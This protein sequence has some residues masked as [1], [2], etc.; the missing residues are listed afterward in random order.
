M[1]IDITKCEIRTPKDPL[2]LRHLYEM[3]AEVFPVERKLFQDI[4]SG[5]HTL[6][7][8]EPY[9]LYQGDEPLGNVSIVMFQLQSGGQLQKAAGIASVATP[10]RYRGIGVAKH[11]MNHVLKVIDAQ[12]LPSILFTSLPKVYTGLGYQVVDQDV[13]QTTVKP[14]DKTVGLMVHQ[15]SFGTP[16]TWWHNSGTVKQKMPASCRRSINSVEKCNSLYNGLKLHRLTRLNRK[17]LETS[18]KLYSGLFPH[19]GKLLRDKEYWQRYGSSVNNSEKTELAFCRRGDKTVGYARLE[20]E[21]DRVLL[22]EFY[23]PAESLEINTA[24]WNCACGA[25]EEKNK[26]LISIAL[27]QTHCLWNFLQQNGLHL[28]P[29]TGTERE[30]FMVRMPKREPI[31]W[32]TGLRWSLSD[33]F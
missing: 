22:N 25:A 8:W 30:T 14:L 24:L 29:E 15:D 20:Y 2:E 21:S 33:K 1:A 19:D 12:N 17:D 9:T 4:I 16:P 23:A 31:K 5:A 7:N 11:L 32:L 18:E 26:T 6:Y 10:E 13:K 28:E 3:L 27:P